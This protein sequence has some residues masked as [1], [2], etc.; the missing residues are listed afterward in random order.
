MV[1]FRI[2]I[3]R[4][5]NRL[6]KEAYFSLLEDKIEIG[7]P[8]EIKKILD[9]GGYSYCWDVGKGSSSDTVVDR[10]KKR[11]HEQGIQQW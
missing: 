11:L 4:S 9:E 3:L 6:A 2:K 7:W 5:N 1:K 10:V 8:Q